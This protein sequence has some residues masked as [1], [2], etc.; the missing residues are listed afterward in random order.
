MR[1]LHTSD[2][3]LG[4][5]LYG[6][7][8]YEE[9]EAFLDW[10]AEAICHEEVDALLVAGDVFD[11]STPSNR[12]QQLYYR[13]LCRVAISC[14]RHVVVVGG[15]HDSPSFLDAPKELLRALDVHV[16][17]SACEDEE[18]EVL[19]LRNKHEAPELIVC[20]VPY[21]RDRDARNVEVGESI[22]DKGRK[23][24]EGIMTHYSRVV[25]LAEKKRAELG[26]EI[27]VVAMGHLFTAGGQT[28]TGDGVRELYIGSLA[29]V[30]ADVFPDSLDY[31]ALG[32]LHVPQTVGQVETRRYSGSPLPMGFGETGQQK[33]ICLVEFSGRQAAVRVRS[34]PVFQE[35]V[36][37]EGDW[38]CLAARI[39]E[40]K[41][42]SAKAWLEITYEGEEVIPDLR[43]RLEEAVDGT[44][45]EVLRVRNDRIVDRVLAQA[46]DEEALDDLDADDV[47]E[48]CLDAH[49]IPDDQR[50]ALQEVY[51]VTI[52][53]LNGNDERAE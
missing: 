36:R 25:A 38:S 5:S 31:V 10:L 45:L 42:T 1:I 48:R 15:N 49:Q 7:K 27:P 52:R 33:G 3:H 26:E 53:S 40:L 18:D 44:E 13:F 29:H 2:W 20:A 37:I 47:F 17:G 14:C 51:Q 8:R 41:A 11:T 28:V 16:I 9:F 43:T 50:Q 30:K 12:A 35:L 6:R 32:H 46:H 39:A 23:L 4:R 22:E 24:A 19:V 34:V 21:L